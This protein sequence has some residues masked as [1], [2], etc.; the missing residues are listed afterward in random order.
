MVIITTIAEVFAYFHV[1]LILVFILARGNGSINEK[2]LYASCKNNIL[3]EIGM[4]LHKVS[5]ILF[6]FYLPQQAMIMAKQ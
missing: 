4:T 6:R 3:S 2:M 5:W 1:F